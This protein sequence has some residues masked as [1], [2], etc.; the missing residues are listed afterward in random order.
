MSISVGENLICDPKTLEN[1]NNLLSCAKER[2][3]RDSSRFVSG[4]FWKI[5]EGE[6]CKALDKSKFPIGILNILVDINFLILSLEST[7]IKLWA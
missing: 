6:V 3:Q 7:K 5:F 1:F 2:L 4:D